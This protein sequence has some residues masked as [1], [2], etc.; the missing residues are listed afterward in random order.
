MSWSALC[1]CPL[2]RVPGSVTAPAT[3]MFLIADVELFFAE[4]KPCAESMPQCVHFNDFVIW[5]THT[6]QT[7]MFGCQP[8]CYVAYTFCGTHKHISSSLTYTVKTSMPEVEPDA[9]SGHS[10]FHDCIHNWDGSVFLQEVSNGIASC[11]KTACKRTFSPST[12]ACV[13]R[14]FVWLNTCW[15]DYLHSSQL[16]RKRSAYE[17]C[18]CRRS[19][20]TH[21]Q[22]VSIL[23]A[24]ANPMR[25]VCN[26]NDEKKNPLWYFTPCRNGSFRSM[27]T[28]LRLQPEKSSWEHR[29]ND[30]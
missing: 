26:S 10:Q 14:T 21:I 5:L 29:L 11:H 20:A 30:Y 27:V 7:V 8:N 23:G 15:W 25:R 28:L 6:E 16:S 4:R 24:R 9:R 19:S 1:L 17:P 3:K 2:L 22:F 13:I 12:S 18:H